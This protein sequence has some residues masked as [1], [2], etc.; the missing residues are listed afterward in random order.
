MKKTLLGVALF[1]VLA[2]PTSA[3]AIPPSEYRSRRDALARALGEAGVFIALSPDPAVRNGDVEWPFRQD[4]DLKYLTGTND[5][6]T[7][8]VLLPSEK[9]WGEVLF[10]RPSDPLEEVWTGP[11]PTAEQVR[12]R[13]SVMRVE[14]FDQ[15]DSFLDAL[16]GG[17][18]WG[19]SPEYNFYRSPAFPN[20]LTHRREGRATVWLLLSDSPMTAAPVKRLLDRLRAAYPDLQFRDAAPHLHRLRERKSLSELTILQRAIDITDEAHRAA[21]KRVP[22]ATHENQLQATIEFTFRDRGADGWSFPSIVASGRNATILHYEVNNAPVERSGLILMD[23]G[24]EVEGYAADIT[25]TVPADGTF[26]PEQRAVHDAVFRAQTESMKLMRP[27]RRYAEVQKRAEEVIGEELLRLGLITRNVTEQVRLYFLHGVGH[28]IGLQV[29]DVFD[30]ARPFEEG[31]VLT[32]EPGIY[33]R[34]ASV[35]ES[36]FY[37]GLTSEERKRV[38]AALV[39]YDGIGVRIE[40]DLLVTA[41]EP[42]LLSKSPRS[43][44][45]TEEFMGKGL[46]R[47]AVP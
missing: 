33:V 4:D 7:A 42:R 5:R 45:E 44:A 16:F 32:N 12:A 37:K 38:D 25:R 6:Q 19:P 15:F 9:E 28:H 22:T 2:V 47:K 17:R 3:Q 10:T 14:R 23:I 1:L 27:G 43:A 30:R 26:T 29:H 41:G 18:R 24:A 39:R 40:D 20:F 21:M 8:L 13:G 46:Q 11:T 31:M 36:F 34:R 35:V